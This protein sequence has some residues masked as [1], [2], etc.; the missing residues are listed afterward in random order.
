M[1]AAKVVGVTP[2]VAEATVTMSR[3]GGGG[4][5]MA[6]M[7]IKVDLG[8]AGY[9]PMTFSDDPTMTPLSRDTPRCHQVTVVFNLWL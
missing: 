3:L 8:Q 2:T 7:R 1:A 4:V 5:A 6:K 9:D